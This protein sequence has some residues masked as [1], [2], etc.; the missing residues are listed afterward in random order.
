MDDDVHRLLRGANATGEVDERI[1]IMVAE[2]S[3]VAH[4]VFA[5]SQRR[6]AKGRDGRAIR[7]THSPAIFDARRRYRRVRRTARAVGSFPRGFGRGERSRKRGF[8][9]SGVGIGLGRSRATP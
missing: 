6:S 4:R 3:T 7:H 5:R 9:C 2:E 1:T 8:S